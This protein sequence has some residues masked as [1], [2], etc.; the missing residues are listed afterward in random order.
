MFSWYFKYSTV[1]LLSYELGS[2]D[3]IHPSWSV[4]WPQGPFQMMLGC[5]ALRL[6]FSA[7]RDF[8]NH[9]GNAN[10]TS[11][12]NTSCLLALLRECSNSFNF[13]NV[14]ELSV[15]EQVKTALKLR[16]RM[17]NLPSCA[18]VHVL[19][20]TL[21]FVNS[22]CCLAEYDEEMYQNLKCSCR[23]CVFLIETYCFVTFSLPSL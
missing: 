4:S 18:H 9:D 17:K 12:E 5:R 1:W 14:I 6:P 3:N 8:E 16:E 7:F 19:H 22:C 13:Y 2:H 20:K 15:T 11:L 23:A 21:N 10:E